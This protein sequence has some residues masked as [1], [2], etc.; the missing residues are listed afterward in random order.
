M[1]HCVLLIYPPCVQVE[2]LAHWA[3]QESICGGI[4]DFTARYFEGSELVEKQGGKLRIAL[5]AQ[6]GVTLA[7]IFGL[8]EDHRAELRIGDYALVSVPRYSTAGLICTVG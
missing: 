6:Q 5:P 7:T 3:L 8:L 1:S 2:D 4:L